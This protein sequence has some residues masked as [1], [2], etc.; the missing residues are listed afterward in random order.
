MNSRPGTLWVPKYYVRRLLVD[1]RAPK[2][3][4]VHV[5]WILWGNIMFFPTLELKSHFGVHSAS[6]IR[7]MGLRKPLR[8]TYNLQC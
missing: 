3:M 7:L 4:Y 8:S 6:G 5:T 2:A 1:I